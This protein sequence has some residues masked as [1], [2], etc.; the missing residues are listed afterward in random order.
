MKNIACVFGIA[1]TVCAVAAP[2]G[3]YLSYLGSNVGNGGT[4]ELSNFVGAE[5]G[6]SIS[7]TTRSGLYGVRSGYGAHDFYGV[8]ALGF[9]ALANASLASNVFAVGTSAA[10]DASDISN[11]AFFGAN[12]GRSASHVSDVFVVGDG[13]GRNMT[14]VTGRI[15][16]L[17]LLYVDRNSGGFRLGDPATGLSYSDGVLRL[18]GALVTDT[19]ASFGFDFDLC[20][21]PAGNDANDGLTLAAAKRTLAGAVAAANANGGKNLVVAVMPGDY[22]PPYL[23]FGAT[24]S[25]VFRAVGDVEKTRIVGGTN[26]VCAWNTARCEWRGFTFTGFNGYGPIT[27]NDELAP[28]GSTSYKFAPR[29]ADMSFVDCRFVDNCFATYFTYTA[30]NSCY[31]KN[32]IFD[33]NTYMVSH[34]DASPSYGVVY[35]NCDMYDCVVD[36]ITLTGTY[37]ETNSMYSVIFASGTAQ[38]CLFRLPSAASR[39]IDGTYSFKNVTVI[40]PSLWAVAMH[41]SLAKHTPP[42]TAS[43]AENCFYVIEDATPGNSAEY[44]VPGAD[45]AEVL[46]CVEGVYVITDGSANLTE[47]GVAADMD[48][49]SV[50]DDGQ[51]DYGY[52]SSGL[53]VTKAAVATKADASALSDY[54]KS[55]DLAAVATSG[56]YTNLTDTPTIPSKVSELTNDAGY[57]TAKTETDPKFSAWTNGYWVAIGNRSWASE[58]GSA[59]AIGLKAEANGEGSV[60]IGHGAETHDDNSVAI[61]MLSEVVGAGSIAIGLFAKTSADHSVAIGSVWDER[62]GDNVGARAWNAN[63]VAFIYSPAE[64]Y[65]S[66]SYKNKGKT[67][68]SY[69][70]ER[71]LATNTYTKAEA[72]AKFSGGGGTVAEKK[73]A[74]FIIPATAEFPDFELKASTNNYAKA[75]GEAEPFCPFY[76]SSTFNG[77]TTWAGDAFRLYACYSKLN[78]DGDAR[79]WRRI[80]NTLDRGVASLDLPATAFAVIVDPALLGRDQG[81]AWLSDANDE[82]VWNYLRISNSHPETEVEDDDTSP[83]LWRPIMPVR[84]YAKLP[85]W[86][87]QEP[88]PAE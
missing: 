21:S 19:S 24:N 39:A 14:S 7:T 44:I 33:R 25:I 82:L 59:T 40:A 43:M 74:L 1:A 54:A 81:D 63:S 62:E 53:G 23:D 4:A 35:G 50:R 80:L 77:N 32:C 87:N 42:I 64:F 52:K 27:K 88:Y 72:D 47:D 5:A 69:L 3:P 9:W 18:G 70:D 60:A 46:R 37:G 71:A 66:S 48:C 75:D 78:S 41:G 20:L 13:A 28:S 56:S 30:H 84:W 45:C 79:R 86:A 34:V 57:L 49:P 51:P 61:G 15:D 2:T 85:A 26:S 29:F 11:S 38:N 73:Y 22:E 65:F 58:I 8:N 67:L 36:G 6:A 12:A 83:W 16:V 55:A 68:Q 10:R 76:A 31:F 17:D